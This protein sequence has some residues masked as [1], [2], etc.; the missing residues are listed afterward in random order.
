MTHSFVII[1]I[2]Y[3][4]YILSGFHLSTYIIYVCYFSI[5]TADSVMIVGECCITSLGILLAG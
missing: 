4:F 2:I 5:E 1:V 3:V